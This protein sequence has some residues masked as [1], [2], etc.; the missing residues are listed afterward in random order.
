MFLELL[1]SGDA[2]APLAAGAARSVEPGDADALLSIR[3]AHDLTW[4]T[5]QT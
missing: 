2:H 1:P 5:W 3:D 4:Q